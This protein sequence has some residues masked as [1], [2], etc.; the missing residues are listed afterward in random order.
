[1]AVT[2]QLWKKLIVEITPITIHPTQEQSQELLLWCEHEASSSF[3][4][5]V[6]I[7]LN[8][9]E[10]AKFHDRLPDAFSYDHLPTS[11]YN[12]TRLQRSRYV[13]EMN[14]L[15]DSTNPKVCLTIVGNS[16]TADIMKEL[17][18]ASNVANVSYTEGHKSY[19]HAIFSHSNSLLTAA[20]HGA[21]DYRNRH[22][23][24]Q[25]SPDVAWTCLMYQAT[26][27]A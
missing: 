16:Q 3:A 26:T 14:A 9:P 18:P 11:T 5:K 25:K 15:K 8:V 12:S 10:V 17:P 21:F 13:Q 7:D 19:L 4:T 6:F 1:M 24:A 20:T 2:M 27:W 23:A 22:K